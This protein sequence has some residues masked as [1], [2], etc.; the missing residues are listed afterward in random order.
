MVKAI[1]DEADLDR[2]LCRLKTVWSAQPNDPDWQER[3]FLIEQITAYESKLPEPSAPSLA[4]A[5]E[6]R[7]DQENIGMTASASFCNG[8]IYA[9]HLNGKCCTA[10]SELPCLICAVGEADFG[11]NNIWNVLD[12]L[13]KH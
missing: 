1:A 9:L 10:T 3:C 4:E 8:R 5:I 11:R 6:F 7:L 13:P 2:A 12:A